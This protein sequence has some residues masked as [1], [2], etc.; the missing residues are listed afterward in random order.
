METGRAGIDGV[1]PRWAVDV[2][3]QW[4]ELFGATQ[5]LAK[6]SRVPRTEADLHGGM[7][8]LVFEVG[9]MRFGSTFGHEAEQPGKARGE[10][11]K[12]GGDVVT[13]FGRAA[14]PGHAGEH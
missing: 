1:S 14:V 11:E 13:D 3:D 8:P 7:E 5:D 12:L 2:E 10:M 4:K 9:P 6:E